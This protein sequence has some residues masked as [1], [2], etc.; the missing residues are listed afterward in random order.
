IIMA[1]KIETGVS[2]E[3]ENT[4]IILDEIQEAEGAL[5]SL[6]YFQENAPQYHIISAGSLLGVALSKHTS[7]PVGKVNFL[8]LY[9]MSF[10]EFLNAVGDEPLVGLLE[11][12]DW[13]L[14]TSF[15]SKYVQR[16]KQYYFVGGMPEA[17][18]SFS[19]TSDFEEARIIQKQILNAYEQDFAKHAPHEIV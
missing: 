3:A 14:I 17:V 18:L 4:L 16:L 19:K 9:P 5:T 10:I 8:D 1:L 11:K 6:K 15:K 7:F 12:K 13:K 2:I